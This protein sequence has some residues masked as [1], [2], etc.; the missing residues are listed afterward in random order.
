MNPP[1]RARQ[2][3]ARLRRVLMNPAPHEWLK[4]ASTIPP[5]K[6]VSPLFSLLCDKD[7]RVKWGAVFLMGHVVEELARE[8]MEK[9]RVVIRRIMWNLND[10]SGG[11]GWGMAEAMGEITGRN[12]ALAEEYG[13]ILVSYIQPGGNFLEHP[14]LQKG[15]L[16]GVARLCRARPDKA[17][18][19]E[20]ALS[21][22]LSSND[23]YTK[24]MAAW[25][26]SGL[27][28]L[29]PKDL[30]RLCNDPTPVVLFW[31]GRFVKTTAGRLAKGGPP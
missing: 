18:G 20:K 3:K 11:M 27:A 23:L 9:A 1:E 22:F 6:A 24:T 21:A 28:A 12:E 8:N 26:L 17:P 30:K 10:E 19:A 15:A 25:G 16:W 5:K 14:E 4:A 2:T 29:P 13:R 31:D 7:M